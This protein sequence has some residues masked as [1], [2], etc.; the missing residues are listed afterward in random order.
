M[1]RS[2]RAQSSSLESIYIQPRTP[3]T[4]AARVNG[5]VRSP[6]DSD[7]GAMDEVEMSLLGEDERREAMNGLTLEEE[8][9]YLSQSEKKPMPAK[10]K[11]AIALLIVLCESSS[12]NSYAEMLKIEI[13]LIQGFP[14]C[15]YA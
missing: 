5:G 11:R 15:T 14:V 4:A 3:K 1:P 10:D 6:D 9:A 13:D 8:Q 7:I 12:C 2:P